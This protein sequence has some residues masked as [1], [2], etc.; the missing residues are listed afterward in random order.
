MNR[1]GCEQWNANEK[2]SNSKPKHTN[3]GKTTLVFGRMREYVCFEAA[4]RDLGEN[5]GAYGVQVSILFKVSVSDADGN[6]D[7]NEDEDED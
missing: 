7:E 6:E 3:R 1:N 4:G 5:I 2:K